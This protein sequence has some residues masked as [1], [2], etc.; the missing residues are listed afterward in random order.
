MLVACQAVQQSMNVLSFASI[1]SSITH[2]LI[3]T[4]IT[5][6]FDVL[7]D[8]GVC[9]HLCYS[10]SNQMLTYQLSTT[11]MMTVMY[12]LNGYMHNLYIMNHDVYHNDECLI[13]YYILSTSLYIR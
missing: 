4:S 6:Q 12:L 11:I 2:T 3:P 7:Y 8:I 9:V 5:L 10:F 13:V 1:Y